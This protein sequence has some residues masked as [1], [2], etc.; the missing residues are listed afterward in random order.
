MI[1]VQKS[2]DFPDW[3][4]W[5]HHSEGKTHCEECLMLDDLGRPAGEGLVPR[6]K[7]FVLVRHLDRLPAKRKK[8]ILILFHGFR[9]LHLCHILLNCVAAG[10]NCKHNCGYHGANTNK[11]VDYV[12]S[13]NGLYGQRFIIMGQLQCDPRCKGDISVVSFNEMGCECCSD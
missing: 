4:Q 13:C 2:T 7:L 3:A 8:D 5:T 6:L 1:L 11:R 12:L 10:N 9:Q